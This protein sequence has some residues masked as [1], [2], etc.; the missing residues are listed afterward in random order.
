MIM[1]H[2]NV[3]ILHVDINKSMSHVDINKSYVNIIVLHVDIDRLYV[4]IIMLCVDI[5]R[6]YV[7]LIM[8]HFDIIYL[9][10][11]GQ[12][13]SEWIDRCN[14]MKGTNFIVISVGKFSSNPNPL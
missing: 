13:V 1:L 3:I 9:A 12:K 11:R 5:N 4:N 6:S 10:C 2:V 7:N 8:L 14:N